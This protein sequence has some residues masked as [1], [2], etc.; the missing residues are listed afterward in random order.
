MLWLMEEKLF[1]SANK[2]DLITYSNI[3]TIATD[4]G[5]DYTNGCLLDYNHFIIYYKMIV[6][7]LSKQQEL[8]PDLEAI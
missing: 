5:D 6:I 4:Q 2:N 3:R 1:W 8:D 7:D